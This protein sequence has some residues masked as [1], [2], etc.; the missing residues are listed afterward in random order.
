MRKNPKH[1]GMINSGHASGIVQLQLCHG[2]SGRGEEGCEGCCRGDFSIRISS[3]HPGPCVWPLKRL[4][5]EAMPLLAEHPCVLHCVGWAHVGHRAPPPTS[6]GP[7]T[8][9]S[10]GNEPLL[11]QEKLFLNSPVPS[12]SVVPLMPF[13]GGCWPGTAVDPFLGTPQLIPT[14][15]FA[16]KNQGNNRASLQSFRSYHHSFNCITFCCVPGPSV[17]EQ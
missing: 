5:E 12:A 4:L 11:P 10:M 7:T 3:I 6:S 2:A 16:A 17:S 14:V 13:R 15:C 8:D 1:L 9:I